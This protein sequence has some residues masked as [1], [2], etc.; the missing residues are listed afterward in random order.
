MDGGET[1]FVI[2]LLDCP[3]MDSTFMGT[4]A[5]LAMRLSRVGG[6]KMHL[7]GVC[8][9]NRQSLEDLGLEKLLEIDPPGA[10]C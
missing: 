4:L 8:D 6:G 5:G 10:I 2:D 9:R 3:A 7:N 1:S